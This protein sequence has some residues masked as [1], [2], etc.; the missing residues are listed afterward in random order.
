VRLDS[1]LGTSAGG[2]VAALALV[3]PCW[4]DF[5]LL[6][7]LFVDVADGIFSKKLV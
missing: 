7:F 4:L 3:D 6:L 1:R 2:V 5:L